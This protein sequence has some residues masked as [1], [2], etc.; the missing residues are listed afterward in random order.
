MDLNV[1][2]L[3]TVL[4]EAYEARNK[5]YDIGLGL[6]VSVATLDGIKSQSDD[7]KD[8]LR[9]TLKPWLKGTDPKPTW[10]ALVEA[11]KSCIVEEHQ[12][13]KRLEAKYGCDSKAQGEGTLVCVNDGALYIKLLAACVCPHQVK[14]MSLLLDD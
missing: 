2:D 1:D 5:W 9:E 3:G 14:A 6:K 11:L 7:P 8:C 4:Q 12:L 10:R 13:A